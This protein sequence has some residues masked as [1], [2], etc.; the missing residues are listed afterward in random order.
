MFR[1]CPTVLTLSGP[2][3]CGKSFLSIYLSR[4]ILTLSGNLPTEIYS[5]NIFTEFWDGYY[6]QPLVLYDDLHVDSQN[7]NTDSYKEFISLISI[8][9]YNPNFAVLERKDDTVSPSYVVI[10]TNHP[11]PPYLCDSN[12]IQR[13]HQNLFYCIPNGKPFSSDFNHLDLFLLKT[14]I[15]P[16]IISAYDGDPYLFNN[17]SNFSKHPLYCTREKFLPS[18]IPS[19]IYSQ[20]NKEKLAFNNVLRCIS[21]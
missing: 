2:S 21:T 10:T 16:N 18:E 8:S 11:Y 13:R 20:Y 14:S 1:Q 6:A 19:F 17:I 12:A 15:K 4:Q 7:P 5:R 3:G 9:P